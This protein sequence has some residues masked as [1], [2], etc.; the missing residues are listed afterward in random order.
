MPVPPALRRGRAAGHG[1]RGARVSHPGDR[2]VLVHRSHPDLRRPR[3]LAAARRGTRR[4]GGVGNFQ[5]SPRYF[6]SRTISI[7]CV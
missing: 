3:Q 5:L 6:V 1:V 4:D 2:P 7:A